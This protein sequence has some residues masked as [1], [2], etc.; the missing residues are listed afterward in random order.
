[1]LVKA[2]SVEMPMETVKGTVGTLMVSYFWQIESHFK[3]KF[4]NFGITQVLPGL[5]L[6]NFRDAKDTVQ[7]AENKITHILSIHDNSRP[8]LMVSFDL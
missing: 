3:W 6:G 1:M 7:L 4:L 2:T 5:Y 8:I